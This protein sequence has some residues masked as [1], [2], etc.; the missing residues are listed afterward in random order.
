MQMV[1]LTNSKKH[2][3]LVFTEEVC[4]RLIQAMT[5]KGLVKS[6]FLL[7][8]VCARVRVRCICGLGCGFTCMY[9]C[10]YM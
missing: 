9:V 8:G 10:E 4:Q 7:N 3:G 5:G 1:G 6:L 2:C